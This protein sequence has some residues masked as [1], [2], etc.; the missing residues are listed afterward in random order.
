M[1]MEQA[2]SGNHIFRDSHLPGFD[3]PAAQGKKLEQGHGLLSL[4]ET[5]GVNLLW[6]E[7]RSL[8]SGML[9]S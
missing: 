1:S 7:R 9:R 2:K 4:F 3:L 5:V 8:L 6:L